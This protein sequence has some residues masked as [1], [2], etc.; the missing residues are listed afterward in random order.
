MGL[1]ITDFNFIRFNRCVFTKL[2]LRFIEN[3]LIGTS[4]ALLVEITKAQNALTPIILKLATSWYIFSITVN[5]MST[6]AIIGRIVWI[7]K[8]IKG[9]LG[10][11]HSRTYTGIVAM[12]I[13]SASLYSIFG[14]IFVVA[15][16]K[17]N[18]FS[19]VVLPSLGNLEVS[20]SFII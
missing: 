17:E 19:E 7:R 18:F 10:K 6:L 16:L 4:I 2:S 13:E 5:V 12:I 3:T 1:R 14:I 15:Y 11:E 20:C 9:V 8:D